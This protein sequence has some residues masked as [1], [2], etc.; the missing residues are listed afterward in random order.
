M[1]SLTVFFLPVL[2]CFACNKPVAETALT[3]KV[4]TYLTETI[5]R[6]NIAGLTVAITRN[7]SVIYAG[8]FG[9]RNVETKERLTPH[10]IFHWAS[11]SKTF[12][13]TAI[14]QLWEQ[15]KINLDEKLTMYLP[16]FRQ[17]DVFYK[18]ITI[19][20]MLNHTSGIGDVDNYEWDKPQYDSGALERFVRSTANDKMLFAPGTDMQYSNT[21]FETLGDVIAKVSGMSFETYVRKNILDPLEMNTTSF[22]YP[23][24]P[25]SLRVSGHQ[26]AGKPVVSKHY[27]YNRMH[28]PSS[29][30]NSNVLEMTHYAFA[31]L[32]RGAYKDKR[33]LADATYDLLWTNSVDME[34]K[35][36]IGLAWWLGERNGV[37]MMSHSGG[38]TGFRSFFMLVPEK[39][40]SIMLVG[41]YELLRTYDLAASLLDIL[42]NIEPLPGRQQIGFKFAEVMQAEGIDAAKAFFKKTEVDSAQRKFYL[43]AEDDGALAYPAYLYM[44]HEMYPEAI[45]IFKFNLE[46]FPTSG[47]AYSHLATGYARSGDKVLARQYFKKAI[48]LLPQEASFREELNKR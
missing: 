10:H 11:V 41:N 39:H 45:E 20:Q 12:V 36:E 28:G 31:H 38:D 46:Q 44:E 25:D 43:W 9:Y 22:L 17:Q 37:K 47:W 2:F 8:A 4:N 40:I 30:L 35:S 7:D 21:A 19:R 24:I 42:M 18:D 5:D 1:K 6:L 32:H 14:M 29:T 15:K 16:Y 27:P 13:A 33:I 34:G 3:K 26:W 48:E 23:E